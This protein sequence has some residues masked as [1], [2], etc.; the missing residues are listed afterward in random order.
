[1]LGH[2]AAIARPAEAFTS[3][4][5]QVFP[6]KFNL[7]VPRVQTCLFPGDLLILVRTNCAVAMVGVSERDRFR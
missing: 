3:C 7:H 6:Q 2:Q 1:V 5:G 4:R